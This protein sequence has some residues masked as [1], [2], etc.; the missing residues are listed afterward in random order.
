MEKGDIAYMENIGFVRI[1]KIIYEETEIETKVKTGL[2]SHK[3]VGTGTFEKVLKEIWW[4]KVGYEFEKRMTTSTLAVYYDWEEMILK[5]K[6]LLH[7]AKILIK[8]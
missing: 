1:H 8:D 5:A 4:I 2:F 3:K 6:L 7:Q